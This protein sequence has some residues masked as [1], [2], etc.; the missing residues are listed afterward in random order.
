VSGGLEGN[1]GGGSRQLNDGKCDGAVAVT[2]RAGGKGCSIWRG[3]PFI[4]A[5]GSWKMAAQVAAGGDRAT[6]IPRVTEQ[7]WPRLARVALLFRPCG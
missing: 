4:A 2:G 1:R 7:R 3:A 6:A 5:V